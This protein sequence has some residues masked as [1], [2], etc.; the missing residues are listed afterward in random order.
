M[1]H[2]ISRRSLF[3]GAWLK[4][5]P[6]PSPVVV[7]SETLAARARTFQSEI[8][9]RAQG[10]GPLRAVVAERLCLLAMRAECSVCAEVCPEKGAITLSER[11]V[12]I[13]PSAC[14]G[15]GRCVE[16]CPAPIPALALRASREVRS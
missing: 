14:T 4:D 11:R 16:R 10:T 6:A 2:G 13:D 8:A 12:H 5:T 9:Q 1:T 15:C 7:L 3:L